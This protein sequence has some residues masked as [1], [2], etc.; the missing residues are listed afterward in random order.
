MPVEAAKAVALAGGGAGLQ[1]LLRGVDAGGLQFR[2]ERR[3]DALDVFDLHGGTPA[4]ARPA[5]TESMAQYAKLSELSSAS[6]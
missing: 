6:K 3:P 5:R 2:G 1:Q 4:L